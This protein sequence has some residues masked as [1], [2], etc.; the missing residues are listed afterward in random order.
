M[1]TLLSCNATGLF[2]NGLVQTLS[3]DQQGVVVIHGI[4]NDRTP[5][6]ANGAGKT[7]LINSIT[8]ILFGENPTGRGDTDIVNSVWSRGCWAQ[9]RF[10]LQD[11]REYRVTMTRGWKGE[12]P[13]KAT[14]TLPCAIHE[15]GDRLDGTDL[16]FEELVHAKWTDLRGTKTLDTRKRVLAI[17]GMSYDQFLATSYLAQ[18]RGLAFIS[19]KNKDR[20]QLITELTDMSVWD[21]C[22][23]EARTRFALAETSARIHKTGVEG[24][25]AVLNAT[26]PAITEDEAGQHSLRVMQLSEQLE[27]NRSWSSGIKDY[28]DTASADLAG[29][30]ADLNKLN[31]SA[32]AVNV[33]ILEAKYELQRLDASLAAPSTVPKVDRTKEIRDNLERVRWMWNQAAHKLV[34]KPGGGDQCDRCGSHV[35]AA[36]SLDYQARLEAE[37]EVYKNDVDNI[38]LELTEQ[39][40]KDEAET[41]RLRDEAFSEIR[42]KQYNVQLTIGS[43]AS[44][45]AGFSSEITRLANVIKTTEASIQS[46][47]ED[48]HKLDSGCVSINA[49]IARLV[50]ILDR[51]EEVAARRV[52]LVK[53]IAD[54]KEK[55]SEAEARVAVLAAVIK[56]MG[57]KGIK[58]YKFGSI[59]A[60]LNDLIADNIRILT[61]GQVQVW[62][63]P[64]KE[65]ANAKTDDDIVAEIQIFVREG[66]KDEVELA[67]YSGAERQQI[68]L[69]I[70][71]AFNQLAV[72]QGGGTNMLALDEIFGMFD[73]ASSASALRFIESIK[74]SNWGTIFVITHSPFIR[75]H[76][77]Y[78]Q[79]WTAVKNQHITRIE[80]SN[81]RTDRSVI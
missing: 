11:Q 67:L 79:I 55:L 10:R 50:D 71:R 12:Y 25:E 22:C 32:Y 28:I 75:D 57:D 62:F 19:G 26:P 2:S 64:W 36:T 39:W 18:Q 72:Q 3:L 9:V 31:G 8:H 46:C 81:V 80:T 56:G 52:Q 23:V 45:A 60:K 21:R 37:I 58:A 7:S 42:T 16:Y 47:R 69:A 5:P 29:A 63:S 20:M 4:N 27:T 74:A 41:T 15:N 34:E 38:T 33:K 54:G 65:R 76:I 40:A 77:S 49:E 24:A 44:E 61:D 13:D 17:L 53:S 68:V 51:H 35:S 1:L 73:E 48:A 70:I 43:L 30:K 14:E 66:P 59:I 6:T 78:N